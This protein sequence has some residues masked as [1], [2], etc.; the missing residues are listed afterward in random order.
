[1]SVDALAER[2]DGSGQD[3]RAQLA[4]QRDHVGGATHAHGTHAWVL[5]LPAGVQR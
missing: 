3:V 2:V 5:V 1:M 4:A